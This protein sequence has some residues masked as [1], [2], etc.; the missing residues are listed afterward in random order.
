MNVKSKDEISL[1]WLFKQSSPD[2]WN[3]NNT[4][5]ANVLGIDEELIEKLKSDVALG[6]QIELNESASTRLPLLLSINKAIYNISPNGQESLF[7]T[8]PNSGNFLNGLSI[9]EFLIEDAT[10]DAMAEIITWL[11]SRI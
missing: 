5:L 4:D 11:K 2:R 10:T 1:Q 8:S 6:K 9:K 3:L 7:F